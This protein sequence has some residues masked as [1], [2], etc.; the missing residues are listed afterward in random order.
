[1]PNGYGVYTWPDGSRYEGD[2]MN[3]VK[4][5]RGKYTWPRCARTRRPPKRRRADLHPPSG[6]VYEGEWNAGRMHGQGTYSAKDGTRYQ[7][8]WAA[9]LKSGLGARNRLRTAAPS[10]CLPRRSR[11]AAGHKRFPNGDQYQGLWRNGQP[12]GPGMYKAR[13]TDTPRRGRHVLTRGLGTQWVNGNEFN[14]EWVGGLM[15]GRGTFVWSSGERYDGEWRDGKEEGRGTFTWPDGSYFD[16]NWVGGEKHGV[17]IWAP[18]VAPAD[19]ATSAGAPRDA[20]LREYDRGS[21]VREELVPA[22]QRPVGDPVAGRPAVKTRKVRE[23][24][25]GETIFKGA[26]SYDLMLQL[27]LGVR[28]SVGRVTPERPRELTEKDYA[29]N[30]PLASVSARFPRRGSSTTPPHASHDFK[31]KDYCPMVFR[32]LRERFGIDAGEYMLSLCGAPAAC[33]ARSLSRLLP[34]A[35]ACR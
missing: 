25:M 1:M 17:G 11:L 23:V 4:H 3:G 26:P 8:S 12:N 29:M 9:D 10:A 27:Q 32:K 5:G 19:A 28:W 16:G 31:W 21:L 14:G 24:R 7:G 22:Q 35:H 34:P 6:A 15:S 18:P 20:V 33:F 30:S 2:W 13:V